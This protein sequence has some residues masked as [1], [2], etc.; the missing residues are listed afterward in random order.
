L[1]KT[2]MPSNLKKLIRARREKTGETHQTALRQVRR[3]RPPGRFEALVHHVV[4]LANER[5]EEYYDAHP[6][7][8]AVPIGDGMMRALFAPVPPR[9]QALRDA[10]LT[11]TEV[12]FRKI[13][14]LY[15]AGEPCND[16]SIRDTELTLRRDPHDIAAMHLSKKMRMP[17]NLAQGLAK[18][19]REDVDLEGPF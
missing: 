6:H 17:D 12:D 11:M 5:N 9:E 16:D 3:Q 19:A 7:R 14:V 4:R 18:A 2:H 8:G 10:L 1:E 13:E 15:Y